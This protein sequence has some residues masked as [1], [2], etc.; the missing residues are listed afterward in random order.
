MGNHSRRIRRAEQRR[1]AKELVRSGALEQLGASSDKSEHVLQPESS[2]E[3]SGPRGDAIAVRSYQSF[4]TTE[5]VAGIF[6]VHPKT[7][8]RWRKRHKL[9][10]LIVGGSVRYDL[11][12]VLRWASA[13]K[14]GI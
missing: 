10:C 14:E 6:K 3:Q 4:A 11:S 12:D 1:Q 7:I 5:T 9:P 8:E 2:W 13:R